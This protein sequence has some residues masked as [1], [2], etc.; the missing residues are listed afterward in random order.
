MDL[1]KAQ[2]DLSIKNLDEIHEVLTIAYEKSQRT[3]VEID[4]DAEIEPTSE[5]RKWLNALMD[6]ASAH[7]LEL[8]H[9]DSFFQYCDITKMSLTPEQHKT[10]IA[11]QQLCQQLKDASHQVLKWAVE[12][13]AKFNEVSCPVSEEIESDHTY[14]EGGY[15]YGRQ[16]EAIVSLAMLEDYQQYRDIYKEIHKDLLFIDPENRVNTAGKRLEVVEGKKMFIETE[17]EM[18]VLVDYGLFQYRKDEKNIPQRYYNSHHHLYSGKKLQALKIF[19][20][21]QFSLLL[22]IEPIE[23][24]GIMVKDDLTDETLL[25]V[26][27]GIHQ[28]AKTHRNYAVLTHYLRTP[29]FV[30][31]TGASIPVSLDSNEGKKMWKIYEQLIQHH[32][33]NHFALDKKTYLQCITD[34]FKIAIHEDLIK[35]VASNNLPM[36]YHQVY[37][38]SNH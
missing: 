17:Q 38:N 1:N 9:V 29:E 4:F 6:M 11:C 10:M 18:N 25:L 23:Q 30:M 34:L 31:T 3:R 35:K 28:L 15:S 20:E 22:I 13:K 27:R 7:L 2:M 14:P 8:S 16:S 5:K 32:H 19:K 26:D 12:A 33:Q 21:A 37:G 36:N 24:H